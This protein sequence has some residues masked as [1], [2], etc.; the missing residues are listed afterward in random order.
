MNTINYTYN[1]ISANTEA[2][3]LD[4]VYKSMNIAHLDVVLTIPISDPG[5]AAHVAVIIKQLAPFAAWNTQ[6]DV[7]IVET[8]GL[9][10]SSQRSLM[11]LVGSTD[12]ITSIIQSQ[13]PQIGD[14]D[15]AYLNQNLISI[16]AEQV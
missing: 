9:T 5:D 13:Q 15:R 2:S 11:N 14:F 10:E 8:S 7:P 6:N 4:V 3:T 16:T 12:S 1:V